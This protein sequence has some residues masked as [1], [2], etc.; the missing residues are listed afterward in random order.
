M[1]YKKKPLPLDYSIKERNPCFSYN[2][3]NMFSYVSLQI[4]TSLKVLSAGSIR[5]ELTMKTTATSSVYVAVGFSLD[6]MMV[7][8]RS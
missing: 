4:V 1:R 3:V 5:V 8:V 7:S 2:P 6:D